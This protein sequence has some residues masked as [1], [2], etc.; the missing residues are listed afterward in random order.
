MFFPVG[1]SWLSRHFQRVQAR[2][3][4][5][6]RHTTRPVEN[7]LITTKGLQERI[8]LFYLNGTTAKH[9]KNS[10]FNSNSSCVSEVIF[11]WWFIPCIWDLWVTNDR[12]ALSRDLLIQEKE[13]VWESHYSYLSQANKLLTTCIRT[14][15]SQNYIQFNNELY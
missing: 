4:K 2:R 11:S 5:K 1:L 13:L 10:N 14:I 15:I 9:E 8:Q 7:V 12:P 6:L 3:Q